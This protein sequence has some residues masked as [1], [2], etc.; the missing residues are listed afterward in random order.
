LGTWGAVVMHRDRGAPDFAAR[1]VDL[2]ASLSR[3][4]A[5]ALQRVSLRPDLSTHGVNG[6]DR[7]PGLIFLDD[8]DGIEMANDAAP[9]WLDELSH[10]PRRLPVVV[11]AVARRARAIA[12]GAVTAAATARVR[13]PSGRWVLVRGSVLGNGT[14]ARTAVTL[15]PAQAPELASLIVAAYGLTARERR[16]TELVAQGLPTSAIAARLHLSAYTVQDHLKAIFGKLDVSSR[17]M[18]VARLFV[19]HYQVDG[20]L[21]DS[22]RFDPALL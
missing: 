13:A 11:T 4:F 8:D 7:D 12:S 9:A 19:D 5:E 20:R 14:G 3:A 6:P 1:D 21:S 18:L 15:E 2:L 16:V 10:E 17:A 22:R